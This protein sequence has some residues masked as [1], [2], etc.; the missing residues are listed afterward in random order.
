MESQQ[1]ASQAASS[2]TLSDM[3]LSEST[4]SPNQQ[5]E[6][7]ALLYDYSDL[8]ATNDGPLGRTSVVKHAIHTN[9]HPIRQPVRRQL[10]ALQDV[11]DT[12]VQ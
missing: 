9:G 1:P 2:V 7:F 3:D 6:L 11:I 8:F 5:Q 4:L 10:K 12:E